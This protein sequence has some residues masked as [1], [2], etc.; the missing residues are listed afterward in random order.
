MMCYWCDQVDCV[1]TCFICSEKF[2]SFG[3]R[4]RESVCLKPEHAT[5]CM[6][7]T[8]FHVWSKDFDVP[9][10]CFLCNA[11]NSLMKRGFKS[12]LPLFCHGDV[13]EHHYVQIRRS[14]RIQQNP[15]HVPFDPKVDGVFIV[16]I[17]SCNHSCIDVLHLMCEFRLLAEMDF[18]KSDGLLCF[19]LLRELFF[20]SWYS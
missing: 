9:V 20:W 19:V 8:E 4:S 6:S 1:C 11:D 2:E 16:F 3:W 7:C 18:Q 13:V 14:L 15:F 10:Q 12:P 17:Y 5:V